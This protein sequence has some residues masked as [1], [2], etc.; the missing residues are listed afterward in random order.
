MNLNIRHFEQVFRP[1]ALKKGFSLFG[2]EEVLPLSRS[3][4]NTR[5]FEILGEVLTLKRE[6]DQVSSVRCSCGVPYCEHLAAVLISFQ[7]TAL[8]SLIKR[9]PLHKSES[10]KVNRRVLSSFEE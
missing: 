2:K 7:K 6:G 9:K 5:K 10:S 8:Q 4:G 1:N 3:E